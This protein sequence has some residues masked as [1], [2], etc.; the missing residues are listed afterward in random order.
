VGGHSVPELYTKPK[1]IIFQASDTYLYS[2][3]FLQAWAPSKLPEGG[4]VAWR[5]ALVPGWLALRWPQTQFMDPRCW[6]PVPGFGPGVATAGQLGTWISQERVTLPEDIMEDPR[7][8]D[9]G[10][11]CIPL[12]R[13]E[14]ADRL[15]RKLRK[16]LLRPILDPQDET[17]QVALELRQVLL[18]YV[19]KDAL[20]SS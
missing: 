5:G 1:G 13:P 12:V 8:I 6:M 11:G 2:A 19:P 3:K 17:A 14:L 20:T 16:L 7:A 18:T 15:A 4:R 10:G 9:L